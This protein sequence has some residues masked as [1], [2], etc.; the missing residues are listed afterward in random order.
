M[1]AAVVLVTDCEKTFKPFIQSAFFC[2]RFTAETS[3][4]G[5]IEIENVNSSGE[6]L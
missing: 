6:N 1:R 2:L 3:G 5:A 4:L